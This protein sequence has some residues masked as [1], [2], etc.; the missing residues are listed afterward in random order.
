MSHFPSLDVTRIYLAPHGLA[1]AR[2]AGLRARIV[3]TAWREH[4]GNWDALLDSLRA[5]L[6][7]PGMSGRVELRLAS[8]L[9]H[10]AVLPFDPAL[11]APDLEQLAAQ[12]LITR[13]FGIDGDA[14]PQ[15]IGLSG[16][17]YG[18]ARLVAALDESRARALEDIVAQARC[19]L[20]GLLPVVVPVFAAT[21]VARGRA[22]GTLALV[23]G[24]RVLLVDHENDAPVALRIRPWHAGEDLAAVAVPLPQ[25]MTAL[26]VAPGENTRLVAPWQD[27]VLHQPS[28]STRYADPRV[29]LAACGR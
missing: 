8:P 24:D 23:E 27:A 13:T 14:R 21:R 7:G 29:A 2:R 25:A 22:R 17:R 18:A 1:V 10:L 15:R 16:A 28:A 6:A 4:A 26:R 11:H 20:A 12:S 5:A 9:L 19:R 3:A